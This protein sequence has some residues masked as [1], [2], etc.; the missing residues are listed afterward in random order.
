MFIVKDLRKIPE[1][2]SDPNDE[3]TE[4]KLAR[5]YFLLLC[6]ITR[7][8]EFKGN[9]DV[10]VNTATDESLSKVAY[11]SLYNNGLNTLNGISIFSKSNIIT[12]NLGKN[13]LREIPSEVYIFYVFKIFII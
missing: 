13:F 3:R 12:I 5:R 1:I 10:L 6:L 9:L 4:L 7:G 11:L 2:L 8:P